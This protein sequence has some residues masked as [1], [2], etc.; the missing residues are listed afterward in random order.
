MS[1]GPGPA[2]F[3]PNFTSGVSTIGDITVQFNTDNFDNQGFIENR[4]FM[5]T[6]FAYS[7]G[8]AP[9]VSS[10]DYDGV[11]MT[12]ASTVTI[13]GAGPRV[14][15]W[16]YYMLEADLPAVAGL[17]DVVVQTTN[18]SANL[19]L[20]GGHFKNLVQQAPVDSGTNTLT[21]ATLISVTI[22]KAL[23]HM[24]YGSYGMN[25]WDGVSDN[26][27]FNHSQVKIFE[28]NTIDGNVTA[29]YD[30]S[31]AF[32]ITDFIGDSNADAAKMVAIGTVW[33]DLP[34]TQ[35]TYATTVVATSI[36]EASLLVPIEF[37]STTNVVSLVNADLHRNRGYV[38]TV[39]VQSNVTSS[40]ER[41]V[42]F[43]GSVFG[44]SDVV[45]GQFLRAVDFA[46]DVVAL[47]DAP[48]NIDVVRP[49]SAVV[50]AVST[51]TAQFGSDFEENRSSLTPGAYVELFEVDTTVIGG[52]E[53][54]RFITHG[55]DVS[56]VI[57]QGE[58]FTRFPI[59]IEG[60]EWNA[61]AQSPPQPTLRLS[62]VN[63]IVL[64]AVVGLGDLVGAKVT[65]WRTYAQFLD[66]Q[67]TADPNAHYPPD[68]YFIQQKINHSKI[69]LEWTLS[70]ALYL[71]GLRLPKRQV[72]RDLIE[73]NAFAPG[74]SQ[75]RFRGR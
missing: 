21:S 50:D 2:L 9:S 23:N 73:G 13:G 3:T 38:T 63:K 31:V 65:R 66:G 11:A 68:I 58:T 49:F 14:T 1:Q 39:A 18:A 16:H 26:F 15:L 36:V 47:V 60:F 59:E 44:T 35:V 54:F 72:L 71:P 33:E 24:F 20:G 37:E 30:N 34:S 75:V 55:Y 28:L 42:T 40:L 27:T 17:Y 52:F 56:E 41:S 7:N 51:V 48:S 8:T 29:A 22:D 53:I 67:P 70:S 61:T 57:W 43:D 64:A 32:I 45:V 12:L 69:L 4:I 25:N 10:I 5:V 62:N 6:L 74:V 19:V 46:S